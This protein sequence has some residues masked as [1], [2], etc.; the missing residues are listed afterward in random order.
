MA[1]GNA[2]ELT[3]TSFALFLGLV[4]FARRSVLSVY[5]AIFLGAL[6]VLFRFSNSAIEHVDLTEDLV[7][8]MGLLIIPMV[9]GSRADLVASLLLMFEFL[10]NN[11]LRMHFDIVN[12]GLDPVG[13]S[14]DMLLC[15]TFAMI[16]HRMDR[17]IVYLGASI[18]LIQILGHTMMWL[19]PDMPSEVYMVFRQMPVPLLILFINVATLASLVKKTRKTGA[20]FWRDVAFGEKDAKAGLRIPPVSEWKFQL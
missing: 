19:T 3:L 9:L 11:L 14:M 17:L 15:M 6:F 10:A 1:V 13:A 2:I 7:I 18:Y 16:A 8:T 4:L 5:P 20:K 12:E